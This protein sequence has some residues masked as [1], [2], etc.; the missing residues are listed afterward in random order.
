MI[1]VHGELKTLKSHYGMTYMCMGFDSMLLMNPKVHI[2]YILRWEKSDGAFL[3]TVC[4]AVLRFHKVFNFKMSLDYA[5]PTA[6]MC[7]FSIDGIEREPLQCQ[8]GFKSYRWRIA[9]NWPQGKLEF[10]APDFT[11]T[12]IGSPSVQHSQSLPAD[13]RIIG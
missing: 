7:P 11:Q 12:L 5:S 10:E 13:E 2:D 9:I 8:T 6:G 4:Q 3:F 1:W